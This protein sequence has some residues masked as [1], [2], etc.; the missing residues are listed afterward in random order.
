MT[1]SKKIFFP[2][3]LSCFL[4]LGASARDLTRTEMEQAVRYS[5]IA[6]MKAIAYEKLWGAGGQSPRNEQEL[7]ATCNKLP[8]AELELELQNKRK[9]ISS[10]TSQKDV[11][12]DLD[13]NS[14]LSFESKMKQTEED[15]TES[16]SAFAWGYCDVQ[17][18]KCNDKDTEC[19]G[20]VN[21]YQ[22]SLKNLFADKTAIDNGVKGLCDKMMKGFAQANKEAVS[23]IEMCRLE[24]DD[25]TEKKNAVEEKIVQDQNIELKMNSPKKAVKKYE[26][27]SS[28]SGTI[29]KSFGASAQ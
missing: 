26:E 25:V 17:G 13:I 3:F 9:V 19:R 1:M 24:Q 23:E 22:K 11:V 15:V 2:V 20:A 10:P 21:L 8:L 5:L 14:G 18:G 12:D 7:L 29:K 16:L 28:G 27:N 6:K 4:L